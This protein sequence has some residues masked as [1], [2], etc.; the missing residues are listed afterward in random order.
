MHTSTIISFLAATGFVAARPQVARAPMKFPNGIGWDIVLQSVN[1]TLQQLKDAPGPVIDIDLWDHYD[2]VTKKNNISELARTKQV[3]CYFSAGSREDWR[4]DAGEF[5]PKD[6]GKELD[7]PWVGERWVDIKSTNVRRIMTNRILR[8]KEAGC[9]AVDPDNVD[10]YDEDHQD[11][12]TYEP[13][14]YAEYIQFL[15][16]EAHRVD[17]AI[18]LKNSLA[19][20]EDV[21][22]EVDFAVNEQCHEFEECDVYVPFTDARKAVFSIEYKERNCT[23]VEGVDL[24]EVFK[25]LKLNETGGQC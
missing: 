14:D 9:H 7:P 16:V 13:A 25:P 19:I 12:Y 23:K 8:A 10:G 6:Y 3:I 17:L 21:I 18:G 15:A 2:N 4:P 20:I 11:G 1:V 24:S 5:D 22:N